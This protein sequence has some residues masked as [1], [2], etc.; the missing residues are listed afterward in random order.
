MLTYQNDEQ[1]K[2]ERKLVN[3]YEQWKIHARKARQELKTDISEKHLAALADSLEKGKNDLMKIYNELRLYKTPD[4]ELRRKV[5]ACEAVTSDIIK[6]VYERLTGINDAAAELAAKEAEYKV[7]LEER[8]Q[9]EKIRTLEE[10]HRK[11]LERQKSEL[12]RLQAE[13]DLKAAHARL[14]AYNREVNQEMDRESVQ[15]DSEIQSYVH[16]ATL[17]RYVTGSAHKCLEGTFYRNDE[18]AYSDAWNKL[19]QRYGQ[20]FVVQRAFREKLSNWPK[21]QSRD[22]EGLTSFS[23]FLNAC[24]QAMPY[25]KGLDILNDCEENQKLMQKLPEWLASRWNRQVTI[26]LTEGKDF[27]CFEE[28]TKFMSIEAEIACNP[29]TSLFALHASESFNDKRGT[30]ILK[31]SKASVFNTQAVLDNGI[32]I[33]TKGKIKFSCRLCQDNSHQ[34][35]KCPDFLKGSLDYRRSYVKDNKLCYGC[36]RPGH[37]VRE[38]RNRHTCDFCKGRHPA[39]LH[40]DNYGKISN[41]KKSLPIESSVQPCETKSTT[42]LSLSVTS[43]GQ[44]V[45]T[46]MIVP[47]WVPYDKNPSREKLVYALLDTQSDA[48]FIEQD[49]SNELQVA[50]YPVKLKLTTMMG[51]NM[52][53]RSERASGLRV[54]GYN[55]AVH[56]KL[57]PA[58]TKNCIPVNQDHIPTHETAKRWSHLTVIADK[59]PPLLSCEVGLLIGY[60]CPKTLVPRQVIPGKDDEPYAVLTDLGWSIVGCSAPHNHAQVSTGHC[61]RVSIKELPAVTPM[62]AVRILESDFRDTQGHDETVSQEDLIFHDKLKESI[63]RNE[64]GRYEMPLPFKERPCLPNNKQLAAVRLNHLKR[65]FI[66][67]EK[68]KDDY[69]NYMTDIIERGDVEE[70]HDDG[71]Y[72]E[73]CDTT[74]ERAL[75]IH[76][77][78]ES[79]SFTFKVVP[80]DQPATRRNILAS[81]ASIYDPLGLIAPYLLKGKGILQE[82]CHQGTGWDDPLPATLKPRWEKW[83]NDLVE[84]KRICIA[85][86]YLPNDFGKVIK[87][88]LHHFSDASTCGYGQCSYLRQK[89]DKGQVHCV[90]VMAKARVSPMRVTTIPRLELTAA[91][92]SVSVSSLLRE[93]LGYSEVEEYF[94]TDSKLVLGYINND[95]RRFHTFV[96][97]RVQKIHRSTSPKQ[98]FYVSTDEN[99]ADNAS[100]GR[101]VDELLSSNWFTG[102]RFLWERELETPSEVVQ[103][104]S[105]GDPEVRKAQTLQTKTS[106]Q[107]GLIDRLSKFSSWSRAIQAVARLLRRIKGDKSNALS[108]VSE[109]EKA[110]RLIIRELQSQAYQEEIKI[111]SKGGQLPS[112]NKLHHFDVFLDTD[113]RLNDASLRTFLYK[114]MAVVNSRPLTVDNLNNPSSLMPLTPNHLIT[115]KSTTALPPPG[116]FEREDLYGRKRWRQVQHLTE[117]FWS[118]WKREY[119]HNISTRQCWHSTKRNLQIGD[120]VMDMEETLPRSQWRLGR[121]SE[122][123]TDNDGLVRRAKILLGEKRLNKKGECTSKR[124]LVERPVQKLVVLLENV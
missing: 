92:V 111:L 66:A 71:T 100:R 45:S 41:K 114:A 33:T 113:G 40:D 36:L 70:V 93:E 22:A 95:A 6:K 73:T 72:G 97:N 69:I 19:N 52:I 48:T 4:A 78:I 31:R 99:P 10:H 64:D 122:T 94:W 12:E 21:I 47:V 58:Y 62:D 84:L 103:D 118:R 65:K 90:L 82:M 11:E 63:R 117:Q 27:P 104:L 74:V 115:M 119:L 55:S 89:N 96:A 23:D 107:S 2:R 5:D 51:E 86:C 85:R 123:V 53:L 29:V 30:T 102:P 101:T 68:Y 106:E 3:V 26:S 59:I 7:L 20:P 81:V 88:E 9:K 109:R 50:T 61:H 24:R 18:E 46:S 1:M 77:S 38:C 112:H 83:L 67:N 49:V 80:K 17:K 60:N 79:D 105:V 34:L 35:C 32:Q 15:P 116:K 75:G 14:V 76:W 8:K 39:C 28:F 54:R 37:S 42:A 43:E 56:I 57:P 124:S 120:I 98:W 25:V 44:S 108:T 87:T 16:S 121:V 91:V 13:R 110:E